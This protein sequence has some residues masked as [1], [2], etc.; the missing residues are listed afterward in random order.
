MFMT[1]GHHGS[2]VPGDADDVAELEGVLSR[3][4]YLFTRVHRNERIAAEAGVPLD[5]AAVVVL[6]QLQAAGPLRAGELA[7]ALG[8]EAPH[9]S[10][11]VQKLQDAGYV[12]RVAVPGDQRARL[13]E[14]TSAGSAA[15]ARIAEE[16]R[17]GIQEALAG[18][19]PGDLHQLA[20][21]LS[22]MLDDFV[23]HSGGPDA[24]EK[25]I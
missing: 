15:S 5:R 24:G 25:R 22:R 16:A 6:R 18:W 23:A 12:V 11:Q 3:L 13:V 10:R 4:A 14:L 1:T 21:L 9:V 19:P 7:D 20:A 8:V 2:A 17:R